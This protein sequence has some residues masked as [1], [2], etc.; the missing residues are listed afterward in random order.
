[1]RYAT[2]YVKQKMLYVT[3]DKMRNLSHVVAVVV[4]NEPLIKKRCYFLLF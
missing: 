1:M 4:F 2:I 3:E